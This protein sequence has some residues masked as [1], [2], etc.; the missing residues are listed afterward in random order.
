MTFARRGREVSGVTWVLA[1]IFFAEFTR[2]MV[3]W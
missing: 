2:T 3:G 1:A